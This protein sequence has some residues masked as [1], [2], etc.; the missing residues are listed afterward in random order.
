[1]N[2]FEVASAVGS[3]RGEIERESGWTLGERLAEA[4]IYIG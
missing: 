3:S 1:M 4:G 2:G